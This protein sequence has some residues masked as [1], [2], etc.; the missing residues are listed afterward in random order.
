[1]AA[2]RSRSSSGKARS[3]SFSSLMPHD[4]TGLS[5][6]PQRDLAD[7]REWLRLGSGG[8]NSTSPSAVLLASAGRAAFS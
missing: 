5:T 7:F 1:M 8:S 6:D 3:R 2:T 4:T